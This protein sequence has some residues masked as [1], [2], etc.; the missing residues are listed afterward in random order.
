MA[1]VPVITPGVGGTPVT[2]L[3]AKVCA[4]L[5]PQTFPAVTVMSPLEAVPEVDTVIVF[6]PAPEVI[7]HPEGRFQLYVVALG[8][9]VTEYVS[10]VLLT[11]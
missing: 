8:T 1:V 11:H 9:A 10:P 2:T 5:V 7:V 6:V 3:T 4:L